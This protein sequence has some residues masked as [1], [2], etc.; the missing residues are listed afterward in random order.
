MD[1][2]KAPVVQGLGDAARPLPH[3]GHRGVT[4]ADLH[5]LDFAGKPRL[6]A[7]VRL[8]GGPEVVLSGLDGERRIGLSVDEGGAPSLAMFDAD[9]QPRVLAMVQE[10]HGGIIMKK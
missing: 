10:G 4:W 3:L 2:D 8:G 9:A 1:Q 6:N 7:Q 5:P